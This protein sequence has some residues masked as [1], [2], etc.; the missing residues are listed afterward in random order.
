MMAA[1]IDGWYCGTSL[2]AGLQSPPMFAK[3]RGRI[4]VRIAGWNQKMV[5]AFLILE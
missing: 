4:G 3:S 2:R 5:I 1:G